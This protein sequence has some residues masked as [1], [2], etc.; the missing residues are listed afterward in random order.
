MSN[1]KVS[2]KSLGRVAAIGDLYDATKDS[3][4]GQSIF[5][6][7]PAIEIETFNNSST[8]IH[9]IYN[10]DSL[11]NNL[12]KCDV[13]AELAVRL[14]LDLNILISLPYTLKCSLT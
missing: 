8:Q 4:C 13:E 2:R 7:V 1:K 10:D 14:D 9:L 11:F 6:D 3:F 12:I 5:A